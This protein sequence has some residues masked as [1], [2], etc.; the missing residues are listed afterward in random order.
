MP[1]I[2]FRREPIYLP[3]SAMTTPPHDRYA[4]A[5]RL[6][7]DCCRVN[8]PVYTEQTSVCVRPSSLAE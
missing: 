2:Q 7:P 8:N 1:L 5:C 3:L 4:E 6:L